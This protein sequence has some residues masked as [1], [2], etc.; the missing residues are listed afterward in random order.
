[1]ALPRSQIFTTLWPALIKMLSGLISA[2]IM[3]HLLHRSRYKKP[4]QGLVEMPQGNQQL[5]GV[6]CYS[7]HPRP[8]WILLNPSPSA[9]SHGLQ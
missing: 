7:P 9:R 5:P 2:W 6:P 4:S 3:P 1:M 8:S